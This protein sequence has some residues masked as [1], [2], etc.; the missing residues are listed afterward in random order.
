L[1]AGGAVPLRELIGGGVPLVVLDDPVEEADVGSVAAL[2]GHAQA[3][4]AVVLR[5]SDIVGVV[6]IEAVAAAL[7]LD[8]IAPGKEKGIGGLYGNPAV[9]PR[10]FVCRKCVPPS[11]RL[12]Q[13]GF[14]APVCP[15]EPSHG[16]MEAE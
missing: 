9:P 14:D 7:P 16:P 1:E 12:P 2:L 3:S 10:G 15:R 5:G 8:Q 4:A 13:G 6:D 11:R